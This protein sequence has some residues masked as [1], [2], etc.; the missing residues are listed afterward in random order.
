MLVTGATS[1]IG[2]EA[3]R[4]AVLWYVIWRERHPQLVQLF[5]RTLKADALYVALTFGF[6]AWRLL[7]FHSTR[8]FNAVPPTLTEPR[9]PKSAAGLSRK[10]ITQPFHH[11]NRIGVVQ[12]SGQPLYF[13][14]RV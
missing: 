2:L 8:R 6:L 10:H 14:N 12:K 4:F 9:S 7:I 1:G 11:G 5:W 13:W 3:A